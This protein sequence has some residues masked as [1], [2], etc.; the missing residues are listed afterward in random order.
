[1]FAKRATDVGA[2]VAFTA[3]WARRQFGDG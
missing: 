2:N 1:M 3:E